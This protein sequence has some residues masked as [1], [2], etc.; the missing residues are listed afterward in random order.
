MYKKALFFLKKNKAF[1]KNV[2]VFVLKRQGVLLR[3]IKCLLMEF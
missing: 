1:L 2:K 3:T